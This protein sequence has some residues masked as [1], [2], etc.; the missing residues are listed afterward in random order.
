[1]QFCPII[2]PMKIGARERWKKHSKFS[3]VY[4]LE[5]NNSS[6]YVKEEIGLKEI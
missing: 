6:Q 1:M 3:I 2:N 4:W 5:F